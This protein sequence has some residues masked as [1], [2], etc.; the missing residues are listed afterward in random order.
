[1][2]IA[3]AWPAVP[4]YKTSTTVN[5]AG[6]LEISPD[7]NSSNFNPVVASLFVV[8]AMP[9]RPATKNRAVQPH[10]IRFVG[11][12]KKSALTFTLD[13]DLI[14]TL[15]DGILKHWLGLDLKHFSCIVEDILE[16]YDLKYIGKFNG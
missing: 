4:K 12:P 1:M 8:G 11:D 10:T 6:S 7:L 14:A 13:R 9:N 3:T 2:P 16:L 5:P 15:E